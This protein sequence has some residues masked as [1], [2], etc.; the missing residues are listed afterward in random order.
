[1][2]GSTTNR[3]APP[4]VAYGIGACRQAQKE[5]DSTDC[6]SIAI[7]TQSASARNAWITLF[8]SKP[9]LLEGV[10]VEMQYIGTVRP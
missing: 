9:F 5:L 8:G 3:L 10:W 2:S 1:M 4:D 7:R 6:Y